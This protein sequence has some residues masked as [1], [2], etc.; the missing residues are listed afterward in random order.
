MA[1]LVQV[2]DSGPGSGW[3]RYT[4]IIGPYVRT[5][6]NN[7]MSPQGFNQACCMV[8][9][10]RRDNLGRQ[11][12]RVRDLPSQVAEAIRIFRHGHNRGCTLE[13]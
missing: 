13:G 5:M 4:V 7:A 6:S 12:Q 11:L 8:W 3:N 10:L 2:Y 1:R 9:E